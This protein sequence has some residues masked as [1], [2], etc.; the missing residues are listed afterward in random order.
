MGSPETA[1]GNVCIAA[2]ASMLWVAGGEGWEEAADGE[3]SGA[4]SSFSMRPAAREGTGDEEKEDSE[5][6][7]GIGVVCSP[8]PPIWHPR[9]STICH[10]MNLTTLY[11][12]GAMGNNYGGGARRMRIHPS[13]A[14]A[15]IPSMARS[16]GTSAAAAKIPSTTRLAKEMVAG[17]SRAAS[18][19]LCASAAHHLSLFLPRAACTS[20]SHE[21]RLLRCPSTANIVYCMRTENIESVMY[22]GWWIMKDHKIMTVFG[23]ALPQTSLIRESHS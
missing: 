5:V 14:A 9:C 23:V 3:E 2:V 10:L 6:G 12:S 13:A 17:P 8:T 20:Q 22:N 7:D 15:K 16:Y 21:S 19:I 11:I 18:H 4:R 1:S